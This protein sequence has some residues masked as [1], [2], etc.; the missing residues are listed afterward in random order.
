M[1][2]GSNPS[3]ASRW[4]SGTL[5]DIKVRQP[6]LI[7]YVRALNMK[8]QNCEVTQVRIGDRCWEILREEQLLS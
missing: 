2:E 3:R 5:S 4:V 6:Q 7:W 8:S 1:M